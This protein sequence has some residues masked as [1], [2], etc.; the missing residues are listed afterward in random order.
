MSF[1]WIESPLAILKEKRYLPPKN[2]ERIFENE[3]ILLIICRYFEKDDLLAFLTVISL[4]S[5]E[6]YNFCR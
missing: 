4:I 2:S 3:D 1:L 6:F 5:K